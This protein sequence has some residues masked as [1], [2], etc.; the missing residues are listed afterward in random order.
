M[1][2]SHTRLG[3]RRV[4][5]SSSGDGGTVAIENAT[6][7]HCDLS[8]SFETA[9][10]DDPQSFLGGTWQDLRRPERSNSVQSY[11]NSSTQESMWKLDLLEHD[12]AHESSHGA[13]DAVLATTPPL[14]NYDVHVSRPS[15]RP[16]FVK[17]NS[18]SEGVNDFDEMSHYLSSSVSSAHSHLHPMTAVSPQRRWQK[19]VP[20]QPKPSYALQHRRAVPFRETRYYNRSFQPYGV[21][22]PPNDRALPVD[23][24]EEENIQD[25]QFEDLRYTR[26]YCYE[27]GPSYGFQNVQVNDQKTQHYLLSQHP[28]L[29]AHQHCQHNHRHQ[30]HY[31]HH[32]HQQQQQQSHQNQYPQHSRHCQSLEDLSI[33]NLQPRSQLTS[34][35]TIEYAPWQVTPTSS[36]S[37]VP[38]V[39]YFEEIAGPLNL[40]LNE[41][42]Q[43]PLGMDSSPPPSTQS[44]SNSALFPDPIATG[45][46]PITDHDSDND[47]TVIVDGSDLE[48]RFH[49]SFNSSPQKSSSSKHESVYEQLINDKPLME[50][51]S[52]RV[53]RG[54]YRCA[55]CPKM[56]SSLLDYAKH[57]DEFQIQRDYKCPFVLCPWKILGLP[58]RPELRR[59]CAI[60]HKME[61]PPE[62]KSSL[63]LGESDFP[64]MEC[65]SPYC[66]KTF[67][68]RDSYARH[69]AMVH[70][71]VDSRFNKRLN[72]ILEDSPYSVGTQQH[73]DYV[74]EELTK[75]KRG[76]KP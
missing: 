48:S 13:F 74:S 34:N 63:K 66:D 47:I 58:R 42:F 41:R 25:F 6:D 28:D 73:I 40:E 69:V 62:L 65:P 18:Y 15:P 2:S 56:F 30:H 76:L 11:S 49:E 72:K 35:E 1:Q 31:A 29:D 46:D 43:Q 20:S 50:A 16:K 24:Y 5:G 59:H 44:S 39:D 27:N 55:H 45:P 32:H 37:D 14:D 19:R 67:F 17:A 51:L 61:I 75:T 10:C 7:R 21:A 64:I 33:P 12:S 38:R 68:R 57:I 26:G 70:D 36:L 52:K 8:S 23:S 22:A 4:G 3:P 53:K 71:K 54:Y 9:V 60:Q